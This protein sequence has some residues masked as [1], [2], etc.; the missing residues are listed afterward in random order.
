MVP[1][2]DHDGQPAQDA[3]GWRLWVSTTGQHWALRCD[4]LTAAQIAAGAWP[5]LW[6]EDGPGLATLI[7]AQDTL[8]ASLSLS[9]GPARRPD[10]SGKDEIKGTASRPT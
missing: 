5:L 10:L 4:I 7:R 3:P 6:A 8:A 1:V 2:P 9:P